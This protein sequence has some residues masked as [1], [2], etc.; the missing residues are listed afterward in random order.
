MRAVPVVVLFTP[1]QASLQNVRSGQSQKKNNILSFSSSLHL[2]RLHSYQR[3]VDPTK[4]K[5]T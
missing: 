2:L 3:E 5:M 4:G 1:F